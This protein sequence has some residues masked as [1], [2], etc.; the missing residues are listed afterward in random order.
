MG[1]IYQIADLEFGGALAFGAQTAVVDLSE[2]V[3]WHQREGFSPPSPKSHS[4][5]GMLSAS[6]QDF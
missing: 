1:T 3:H 2:L 5:A 4:Y 6:L